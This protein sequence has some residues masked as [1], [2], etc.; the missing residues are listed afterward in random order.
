MYDEDSSVV[1]AAIGPVGSWQLR[2]ATLLGIAMIFLAFHSM[3][4]PLLAREREFKCVRNG[5][6]VVQ[7]SQCY[8][9]EQ[10]R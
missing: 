9:D 7:D 5:S 4:Y 3:S 6:A 10:Q 2:K 1:S 8:V